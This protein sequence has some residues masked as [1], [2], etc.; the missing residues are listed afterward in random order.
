MAKR[1]AVRWH[2]SVG[3]WA[4]ISVAHPLA[5]QVASP[6]RV[7][8]TVTDRIRT[9]SVRAASV[10][11]MRLE[12]GPTVSFR[13]VPDERG[14]FHLES[15]P[16]GRYL[17]QLG[18]ATLDSLELALPASELNV[19]AGSTAHTDLS[20]P[21]GDVLRDAVC[22]G[23]KLGKG[24]GAVAGRALD[25]DTEEPLPNAQ[26]VVAWTDVT[27][28]RKSLRAVRREHAG[29]VRTGS[30]G[31][32]R[33]CGVPTDSWLSLQLQHAGKVGGLARVL[34]TEEEGAVVRNLSLSVRTAPSIVVL[35]SL[36]ELSRTPGADR[37]REDSIAAARLGGTASITGIVRS[38]GGQ[39]LADA[40]VRVASGGFITTTSNDGRYSLRG[41]PA[42]TQLFYVRRLGYSTIEGDIELR[43]GRSVMHDVS[44]TRL[45]ALDSVRVVAQR[46]R[47]GDFDQNR[48]SNF[49]AEFLTSTE[50][51]RNHPQQVTDLI[52]RLGGFTISGFGPDAK[53]VSNRAS[54]KN[55]YCTEANVVI[56]GAEHATAN[57]LPVERIYGIEAYRD[58]VTAPLGM[59]ARCGLIVLWTKEYHGKKNLAAPRDSAAAV[60]L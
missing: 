50:I 19:E 15:I 58:E 54:S 33:L 35:D 21:L 26:V 25:A 4:L 49:F 55:H 7:E 43:V 48:R 60:P 14:R 53:V 16:P 59:D 51:E 22:A 27:V 40:E 56:D 32:Y 18:S 31:E 36:E 29:T 17:I 44:L 38:P 6:G 34:V 10:E 45:V 46:G 24:R 13:V 20:L 11:A 3:L 2:A 57:F 42:G 1:A 23:V 12:P 8:G 52:F 47:Y 41:L 9:H 5:A 39:P 37:A 30:R 28:D